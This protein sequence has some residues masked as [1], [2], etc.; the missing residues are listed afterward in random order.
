MS[1]GTATLEGRLEERNSKEFLCP[2]VKGG[3]LCSGL[4]SL[5][6]TSLAI[7]C[8]PQIKPRCDKTEYLALYLTVQAPPPPPEPP[9]CDT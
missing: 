9:P 4:A 6:I 1:F 8:I 3:T 2:Y 7:I 5:V